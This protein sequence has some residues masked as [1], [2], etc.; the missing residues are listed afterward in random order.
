M[1]LLRVGVQRFAMGAPG[2]R[3]CGPAVAEPWLYGVS[4]IAGTDQREYASKL[5]SIEAADTWRRRLD[6]VPAGSVGGARGRP[7][8]ARTP[9]GATSRR[10]SSQ[11]PGN[12]PFF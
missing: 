8:Y 2:C 12:R 5:T 11:G 10:D 3:G 7:D 6:I 4:P 1:T 9:A